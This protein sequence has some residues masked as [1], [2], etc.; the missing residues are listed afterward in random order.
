MVFT[1][2]NY[3]SVLLCLHY[4]LSDVNDYNLLV[5]LCSSD[6]D[7]TSLSFLV[8]NRCIYCVGRH[9]VLRDLMFYHKV[10]QPELPFSNCK[11]SL[12]R[13][14]YLFFE[15]IL[16]LVYSYNSTLWSDWMNFCRISFTAFASFKFFSG[17]LVGGAFETH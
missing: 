1:F 10:C 11:H 14:M 7:S 3:S 6:T 16:C 17:P 4:N 2:H 13:Y 12:D 5:N 15:C 9:L 8:I